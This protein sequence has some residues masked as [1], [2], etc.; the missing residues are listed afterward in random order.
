MQYYGFLWQYFLLHQVF[1]ILE[2]VVLPED[3]CQ[4]QRLSQAE[5]TEL[6]N[7]IT[8]YQ[9]TNPC[10]NYIFFLAV[11]VID[12]SDWIYIGMDLLKIHAI[13]ALF[14]QACHSASNFDKNWLGE[15]V[16]FLSLCPQPTYKAAG[17]CLASFCS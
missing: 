13:V 16:D 2:H 8:D 11:I 6:E 5:E 4:L 7:K 14:Y 17:L 15:G 12:T 1:S 9:E 3:Q 10:G